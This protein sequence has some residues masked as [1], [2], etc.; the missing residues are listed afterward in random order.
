MAESQRT[1]Q[2]IGY[3]HSVGETTPTSRRYTAEET[4]NLTRTRAILAANDVACNDSLMEGQTEERNQIKDDIGYVPSQNQTGRPVC[5]PSALTSKGKKKQEN[6]QR[7]STGKSSVVSK[8]KRGRAQCV[9]CLE[10]ELIASLQEVK[11][12]MNMYG[13]SLQELQG[14]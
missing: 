7:M 11:R 1:L 10:D 5:L 4:A 6:P 12:L 14:E 3:V 2:D 8:R 13:R 9:E